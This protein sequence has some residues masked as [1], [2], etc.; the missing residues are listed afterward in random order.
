MH[1][2]YEDGHPYDYDG[3]YI[4]GCQ[5]SL[6]WPAG[7]SAS[8][9]MTRGP[10]LE[11]AISTYSND[12]VL[13]P[14]SEYGSYDPFCLSVPDGN[15]DS[16]W[17]SHMPDSGH[18]I[19][20]SP[21]SYNPPYTSDYIVGNRNDY[22][23]EAQ[24]S[25]WKYYDYD[26]VTDLEPG[27]DPYWK[28]KPGL[29]P[30]DQRPAMRAPEADTSSTHAHPQRIESMYLCLDRGCQKKFRRKADL[31]RHLAQTHT[32]KEKK[33]KYPC[34]WKRCQRAKEPFGRRDHQR[35]HYRQYHHEDLMPRGSSGREGPRWWDSRQIN[36]D[37]WRCARCL[38]RVKVEDCG[39][40]CPRCKI[41]CET[42]RQYYRTAT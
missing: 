24:G 21:T 36:R 14:N 29:E 26:F 42:E 32:P 25:G 8:T 35:D 27:Q 13:T 18:E 2:Y 37:W 1:I 4:P 7:P 17:A 40:T 31:E 16:H 23:A 41:S 39:Y 3:S 6:E 22:H 9:P 28:L 11:S 19:M 15:Q 20:S 34:D 10:S 33:L 38:S 30:T 12:M 5:S